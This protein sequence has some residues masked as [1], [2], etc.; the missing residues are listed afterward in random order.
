MNDRIET[1]DLSASRRLPAPVA[2]VWKA[3]SEAE[4]VQQWWGPQGFTVPVVRMDFREGGVTLVSMRAPDGTVLYNTWSYTRIQH[5]ESIEFTLRFTNEN[6]DP[7]TPAELGLPPGIPE[8]VPHR[9]VFK[10][11][12]SQRT[13]L[14]V[15][16]YGYPSAELAELS[17]AG[18]DQV[19][20]KLEASLA[21]A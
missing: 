19:F 4:R 16:E 6:G 5:Q 8:A 12:G 15:T 9:I 3:W 18:L 1:H 17:K 10:P 7:L 20:D 21:G 14:T 13:E 2:E 11:A